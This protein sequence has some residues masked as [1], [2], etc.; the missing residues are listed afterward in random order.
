MELKS[1]R[2]LKISEAS[3]QAQAIIEIMLSYDM[4][5]KYW[6]INP[7]TALLNSEVIKLT[8][9]WDFYDRCLHLYSV[10]M[11]TRSGRLLNSNALN[12]F[13]KRLV[14]WFGGRN[15]WNGRECVHHK[16]YPESVNWDLICY[17]GWWDFVD[18]T[19]STCDKCWWGVF[20]EMWNYP[21]TD[22]FIK[23]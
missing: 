23:K 4:P 6:E 20:L 7:C 12:I 5:C 22:R 9:S 21:Y 2:D 19:D 14:K 13:M 10:W 3:P 16:L 1:L 15:P 8:E 18:D 17:E 11:K